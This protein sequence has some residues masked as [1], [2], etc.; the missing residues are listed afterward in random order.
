MERPEAAQTNGPKAKG[1]FGGTLAAYYHQD[2]SKTAAVSWPK[3]STFAI[4]RLHS[5]KGL[6]GT[7]KGIP[8]EPAIHVSIGMKPVPLHSYRLSIDN[9]EIAVPY[10]PAYRTSIIDLQS[11]PRCELD[12]GFD[13]VH[14]HVPRDG[15]DE[16]A[17]DHGIK[18]VKTFKFGICEDDLVIA[19]LTKT[20]LPLA[21]S[22]ETGPA[23]SRSTSSA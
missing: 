22:R 20:I 21:K 14:Y 5:D 15:L 13:Y 17:T 12:C 11:R 6:P 8:E 23:F 4:T 3:E 9:R 7:S 18:P 16:I 1:A 10:I 2:E 19:Q